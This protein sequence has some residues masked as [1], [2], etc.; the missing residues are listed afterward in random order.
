[1]GGSYY[2][3]EVESTSSSSGFSSRADNV[4]KKKDS[5]PSIRPKG[6]F[7]SC[8]RSK[9]PIVIAMDV[10]RSRG[11]DSKILYDKLPM[12]YGQ[13]LIQNYLRKPAISFCAIGDAHANDQAPLQVA[14]FAAGNA[15]DDWL[16][17]LWLEEGGGGTG[18]ESYELAAYYYANRCNL[19]LPEGKKGIFFFTGDEGF[20]DTVDGGQVRS[21]IGEA[22]SDLSSVEVFAELQKKFDV[23]FIFPQKDAEQRKADI[24]AEIQTR[25]DREGAKSGDITASLIWN[26][27]NDL[28]LHCITPD[29][30]EIFYGHKKS[31][32][33]GELDVDMNVSG[34]STK[35]VENIYWP[36]GRAPRGK[37]KFFVQNYAYHECNKKPTKFKVALRIGDKVEHIEGEVS[38]SGSSS[39][40]TVAEFEFKGVKVAEQSEVYENYSDKTILDQW[41]SVIPPE[42]VLVI[43]NPKAI[44]DT[45]LGAIAL[46]AGAKDLN[47]YL[48]DMR[49]R[50]QT[51]DRVEEVK[52]ALKPLSGSLD[53]VEIPDPT[54]SKNQK[55]K[56]TKRL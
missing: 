39:N 29:G 28:D 33:L 45:M 20:Y 3:R 56:K 8:K 50:G 35:P 54:P 42:R 40:V 2:D 47:G 34:E 44:V 27:R 23:F 36:K 24:D 9:R 55:S 12:F 4:M 1:M 13:L 38:G 53:P 52:T 32:C 22:T 10:T 5:R 41:R 46:T 15:L 18:Q 25:L 49:K 43:Q 31:Q 11:D 16:S 7:L 51:P 14:D 48:V 37:Y 6:R 21:I 30:E 19:S 17:D 26:N